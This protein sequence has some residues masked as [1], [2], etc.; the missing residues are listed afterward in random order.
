VTIPVFDNSYLGLPERFYARVDPMQPPAPRLIAINR[1]LACEL[2]FDPDWLASREGLDILTGRLIAEGSEPIAT[3]YA[4]HQFGNFVPQLG[5]GRAILLGEVVDLNGHRRDIQ[6]KG[7]GRTPYSRGGDA[8]IPRER[9]HG[10][11]RHPDD[12]LACRQFDRRQ[13]LAR[14]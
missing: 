12:P 6:L 2:G 10:G 5:D 8:G 4:G 3:A 7:A 9:S 13:R 11:S 14:E 1:N